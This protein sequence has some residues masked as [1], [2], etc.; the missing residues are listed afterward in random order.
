MIALMLSLET[1]KKIESI[2]GPVKYVI[3]IESGGK[4]ERHI[5][6]QV[7]LDLTKPLLRG[8]KLKYKHL[9]TWVEFKYVQLPNFC[10]YCVQIGHNETVCS[11]RKQD[12]SQNCV[13]KK[14]L[15]G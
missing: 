10:Y 9:E 7:E 11:K 15:G 13:I 4:E 1:G 5:K 2:L 8:T 3:V 12:V 6:L 14:Q